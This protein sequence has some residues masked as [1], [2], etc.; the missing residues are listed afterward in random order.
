MSP[1]VP[2]TWDIPDPHDGSLSSSYSCWCL[3]TTASTT[4]TA[5]NYPRLPVPTDTSRWR[6]EAQLSAER[7]AFPSLVQMRLAVAAARCP[8]DVTSPGSRQARV[9][10]LRVEWSHTNGW[11]PQER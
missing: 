9:Q 8:V 6:R 1:F 5:A 3:F 10:A 7:G 4:V 11:P 2:Q